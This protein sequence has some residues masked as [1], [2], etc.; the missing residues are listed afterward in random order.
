MTPFAVIDE[1]GNSGR[2]PTLFVRDTSRIV[3]RGAK[4][5]KTDVMGAN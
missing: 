2:L 3:G 1:Y 5:H 4:E